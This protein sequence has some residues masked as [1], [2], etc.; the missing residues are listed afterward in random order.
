M[1]SLHI[2]CRQE[3]RTN[4]RN[5]LESRNINFIETL[6]LGRTIFVVNREFVDFTIWSKY[7]QYGAML[8]STFTF[9]I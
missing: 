2:S 8:D 6:V 7:S 9:E 3:D 5:D 4:F 1:K